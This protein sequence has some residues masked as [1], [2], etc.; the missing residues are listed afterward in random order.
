MYQV[1]D[2]EIAKLQKDIIILDTRYK[3]TT[4][5]SFE[6]KSMMAMPIK[7]EIKKFFERSK[8]LNTFEEKLEFFQTEVCGP[9]KGEEYHES[10][11]DTTDSHQ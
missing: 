9:S 8:T 2:T 1:Y 3:K 10:I 11:L 6:E 7:G 5:L 4:I